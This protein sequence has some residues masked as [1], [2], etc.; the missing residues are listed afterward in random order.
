MQPFAVFPT[1][2]AAPGDVLFVLLKKALAALE[3]QG[4]RV[5][6]VVCDGAQPNKKLWKLCG[7]S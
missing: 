3:L 7:I 4:A 1:K 5:M 6:S 2:G